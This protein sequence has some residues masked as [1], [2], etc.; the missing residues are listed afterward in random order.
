MLVPSFL[1]VVCPVCDGMLSIVHIATDEGLILIEVCCNDCDHRG[2]KP[3]DF[4]E[5]ELG[6]HDE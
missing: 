1:F 2:T 4:K 6:G 5:L 3:V